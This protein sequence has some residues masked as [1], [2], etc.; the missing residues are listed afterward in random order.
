MRAQ[1]YCGGWVF[2]VYQKAFGNLERPGTRERV[3][4]SLKLCARALGA[5]FRSLVIGDQFWVS[6]R[7]H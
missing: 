2:V 6:M 3:C 4:C 1:K 7:A 5:K